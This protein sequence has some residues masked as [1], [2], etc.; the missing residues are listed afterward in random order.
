MRWA[1]V[2]TAVCLA[3]LLAG[4]EAAVRAAGD[5]LRVPETA[6]SPLLLRK[7][8][9]YEPIRDRDD[10]VVFVGSSV[11]QCGILPSVVA[12]QAGTGHRFYNLGV[13]SGWPDVLDRIVEDHVGSPPTVVMGTL[14]LH[15]LHADEPT[16]ELARYDTSASAVH[17]GLRGALDR[18]W[19]LWRYRSTLRDLDALGRAARGVREFPEVPAPDGSLDCEAEG[20]VIPVETP[21]EQIDDHLEPYATAMVER[22]VRRM[23]ARGIDVVVYSSPM[24]IDR[25]QTYTAATHRRHDRYLDRLDAIQGVCVIRHGMQGS[26]REYLYDRLHTTRAGATEL[27][28]RI[29]AELSPGGTCPLRRS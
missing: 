27:S 4:A 10:L 18:E 12:Q 21:P 26:P 6:F 5:R 17:D 24:R 22:T 29:G 20:R 9:D 1:V 16:D 28:R 19:R 2:A 15:L 3:L 14:L 11:V 8:E 23:R 13:S 7:L 25:H